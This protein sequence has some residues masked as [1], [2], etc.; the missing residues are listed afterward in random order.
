LANS[1]WTGALRLINGAFTGSLQKAHKCGP[2]DGGCLIVAQAFQSV[3]GG[4]LHVLV[5]KNDVANHAV[6][7]KDGQLWDYDGPLEPE[8]FIERYNSHVN[9]PRYICVKHRPFTGWDLSEAIENDALAKRL[10]IMLRY[11]VPPQQKTGPGDIV[12]IT[13]PDFLED[14][15]SGPAYTCG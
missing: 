10:A 6:I 8:A 5:D 1:S 12:A 15:F 7:L 3:I 13:R 14:T 4:E 11:I 2:F 9:N